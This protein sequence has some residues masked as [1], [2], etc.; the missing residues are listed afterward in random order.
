MIKRSKEGLFVEVM[1]E[2]FYLDNIN[3]SID[4]ILNLMKLLREVEKQAEKFAD[5]ELLDL[6]RK[7]I[8][9]YITLLKEIYSD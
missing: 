9:Y 6:V 1:G 3:E 4:D 8:F 2:K 5:E 7:K